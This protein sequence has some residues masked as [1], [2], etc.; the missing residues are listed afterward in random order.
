MTRTVCLLLAVAILFPFPARAVEI[1]LAK[2]YSVRHV[3]EHARKLFDQGGPENIG[4]GLAALE[5]VLGCQEVREG[6]A[7][8]GNFLW[9][10]DSPA[11][12]DLNSVEFVLTHLIPLLLEHGEDFPVDI[13]SRANEAVRLGLEE[14]RRMDV[15]LTY[16]NIAS[17]DCSNSILGGELLSDTEFAERGYARLIAFVRL[18]ADNGTIFEFNS[19]NYTQV[20]MEALGLIQKYSTSSSARIWARLAATRIGLSITL[21]IHPATGRLAGPFSRAYYPVLNYSAD[22]YQRILE[23]WIEEGDI[24]G[25]IGKVLETGTLPRAIEE[26]AHKG[27]GIGTYSYLSTSFSMGTA[28]REVSRQTCPLVIQVDPT[29]ATASGLICSRYSMG[30]SIELDR[31]AA[32]TWGIDTSFYDDGKF[33]GVQHGSRAIGVYAPRGV[34]TWDSFAPASQHKFASARGSL[35]WLDRAAAKHIWVSDREIETLPHRV[36]PGEVVVVESGGAFIALLPLTISDLGYDA[37]IQISERK[38]RLYLDLYNY[39]GPEKVFWDMDRGS[40]FYQGQPQCAFYVEVAE[41]SG[42]SDGIEFARTV[43][44]GAV[45]DE[46]APAFTSYRDRAKRPWTLEYSRGGETLGL[47]VDLMDWELLRRW[48]QDGDLDWP[49]LETAA[50]VHSAAGRLEAAGAVLSCGTAPAL[51]WGDEASNVWAASYYGDPAPLSLTVPGGSVQ[52]ERMG[53][54]MVLWDGGKVTVEALEMSGKPLVE[55]GKL[56]QP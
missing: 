26:T 20:T 7:H 31:P 52:I 56:V 25:W 29:G 19:P 16:T 24:P 11:I 23:K 47:E 32:T 30:D 42:Y 37:P 1:D 38:G 5:A 3:A 54:G 17:M 48:N 51:L 14:I 55:G 43:S 15:A 21:R 10:R 53:P 22:P 6:S 13:R 4:Q 28:S 36:N 8:R 41:K 46:S 33:F 35:V 49:M 39:L 44:T 9:E 12:Q 40:R 18:I 50:A 2:N 27:W 34:E 45:R